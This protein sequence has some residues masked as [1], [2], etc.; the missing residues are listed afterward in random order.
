MADLRIREHPILE[1]E[2]GKEVTI[3]FEGKPVKA[4]ENETIAAA[5][6]ASGVKVFSR[7]FKYRRAR[8]FFCAIGRCSACMMEVD[9]VP[10][11]RTCMVQVRDG[12]KVRRQKGWP[13]TELDLLAPVLSRMDL[14]PSA[15][16]KRMARPSALRRIYLKLMRKFTGI[17]SAKAVGGGAKRP[18]V[19]DVEVAVVGG[20]PAG[21]MAAIE[22]GQLCRS[23]LLIDDKHKLGGQLIKQT[24]KFFGNVSYCAGR[25]GF[26][27]AEEM[28][29]KISKMSS[30]KVLTST[31]AFAY[32]PGEGF[33]AAVRDGSRIVKI[34]AKKY[35]VSTGAYERTLVFEN[36]D[37]PGVYGAGGVQTLMNVYGIKPG[38]AG[39][40]VGSGNVGLI[41]SYQLL[42]AGVDVK[43]IVEVLP[44]VG[45]YLVHAAKVRR[46]GVP[47]LT[48][49]TIVKALGK[50]HV[51]G[52]VIAKVDENFNPIPGTERRIDCDFICI[53]VGLTPTYDL[54]QH[55]KPKMVMVPELGG[56]VPMRDIY[57]RVRRDVYIA[58]DCSGIEEAATAMLEGA[59]AGIHAS[60]M[61]GYGGEEEKRR[62][63]EYMKELEEER[64]SPF[65]ERIK[66]GLKKVLVE[67]IEKL[68]EGGEL[69]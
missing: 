35:V 28:T 55:F 31:S 1:F 17:G 18:E 50:T 48:R 3:Y 36:N 8:G 67:D 7:S 26:K 64:G 63:E 25:R 51:E 32:Y 61:L 34:R 30:V 56:F 10:N 20:G 33:L 29:E 47:I 49:H 66:A 62:I 69:G 46:L 41:V 22:A 24:H 4:Y 52:A 19:Y 27:L 59:I 6:Y 16:L 68:E 12:M 39:L 2:R 60:L 58:G 5:L 65:S 54:I 53:S 38:E 14:S 21:L 43:A 42:Q 37:L 15:Y 23:V 13:S 40:M 11:V 57:G 44:R 9:G 45:G